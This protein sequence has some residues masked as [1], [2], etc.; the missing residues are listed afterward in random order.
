M[1]IWQERSLFAK[2][3]I[4]RIPVSSSHEIVR[5]TALIDWRAMIAVA[6]KARENSKKTLSGP[7]PRYR[8]LLG[9]V[10]LMAVR[11]CN[12]RDAEDLVSHYAP[13]RCLCDLM[14]SDMTLDH[15]SIFEFTQMLGST[16]M[17]AINKLILQHAAL[18]GLADPTHMM[19]DTTAQEARI[20]YPNE[21][22][23]MNRFMSIVSKTAGKLRGKFD[24]LKEDIAT[25]TD[26]VKGL[27]RNAHLF[28]K[29]REQKRKIERKMFHTVKEI[30]RK[31]AAAIKAGASVQSRAGQQLKHV[32]EVMEKLLP[33]INHWYTTGFV[34]AKK[35][36]HL[37]MPEVY[38]IVR[39]KAGKA[40]QFGLKWG[41]NRIGGGFVQGFLLTGRRHGADPAFCKQ[42]LKEHMAIF[43]KAP[44]VFG[45]DRGGDS[46]ANIRFS[47]KSGVKQVG[48]APRG[49]RSWSVSEKMSERIR[50]ERA[51]VEGSIGTIKCRKYGFTKPQ[52]HRTE[53]MERCDHRS[54]LGFN[55][56]KLATLSAE[57][58]AI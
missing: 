41:I 10:V 14:E 15:V 30:Q 49:Q 46:D 58:A 16:G 6:G 51:Q 36:I 9:A 25:A 28:A 47:K 33:Q 32:N 8:Q 22:G 13:A 5:L 31:L 23:L 4:A 7:E 50:C 11:G 3:N 19:S 24:G 56:V 18:K 42:S 2:T 20:P 34:A 53:A 37:Q 54:I 21:A 55:L 40:V 38:S 12:Y 44:E 17:D 1:Q 29:G 45:Y 52:A 26:K 48:I 39:G 35:I 57:A 27:L 43:G